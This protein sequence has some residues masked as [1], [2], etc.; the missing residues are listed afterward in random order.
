MNFYKCD[1]KTVLTPF[2]N[3]TFPENSAGVWEIDCLSNISTVNKTGRS[4]AS[5]P[6]TPSSLSFSLLISFC[7]VDLH[8]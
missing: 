6:Y 8:S 4:V 1:N 5:L 7:P 3:H 2:Y